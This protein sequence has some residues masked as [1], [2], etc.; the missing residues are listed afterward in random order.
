MRDLQKEILGFW[1]EQTKPNQW[2]QVNED[3]DELVRKQFE[4]AYDLGRQGILDGWW[5]TPEGCLAYI[6]LFDQFPRNMFRGTAKAFATDAKALACAEHALKKHF[7]K[8]LPVIQRRFV[9]LPF[10]HSEDMADQNKAVDLFKSIKDDDPLGYDYAI[11]HK[12]VIEKFGRFPGRNKALGRE[13]TKEEEF[14]L[15]DPNNLF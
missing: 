4:G 13:N 8:G 14:F 7:D 2:F 9:Y 3:F 15:A 5:E 10:E 12:E 1:F 6:I 11:K